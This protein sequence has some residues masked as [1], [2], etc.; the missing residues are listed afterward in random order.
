M[1]GEKVNYKPCY[2]LIMAAVLC[3]VACMLWPASSGAEGGVC[4]NE[5]T[6]SNSMVLDE[7]G[8]SPDWIEIYNSTGG[9]VNLQ[10]WCLSDKPGKLTRWVFPERI[11]G[12]GEYLLV[13][14]SGKHRARRSEPLHTDFKISDNDRGIYL[15]DE[16]GVLQDHI[17]I[18]KLP[19]DISY[20]RHRDTGELVYFPS[21]TP[22]KA[23]TSAPYSPVV[24]YSV[25][26]GFY[27]E[28]VSVGLYTEGTDS[29]IYY[30]IDGST[31][32]VA[33]EVYTEPVKIDK[34]TTIRA[35]S[36]KGGHL[37]SPPSGQTYFIGFDSKG[38]AVLA[39]AT[40]HDKLWDPRHGLFR[41]ITYKDYML[42][43]SV[44]VH[45]SYFDEDGNQGFSQDATIG[46]VGA[47]SREV[48]MRP[49]KINAD[50][51]V[52]PMHEEFKYKLLKKDIEA[53]RHIQ[54]RN[55]NQ[56][57]VRY[58]ADPECMPTMGM[59]NALFC[60]LVRGLEGIE[61]R[62]DN[63]PVLF[64]IN[65]KNYGMMNIGEKRDNTGISEN[66]P[67]VR[68]SDVDLVVVR[69]DM[70]M[71]IGRH[72]LG[73]GA[74]YIRHDSRVVYKGYVQDGAIEYEEISASARRTGSTRAV[75]DFIALDPT[76]SSQ[77]DPKGYIASMAAHTIACNTDYGMNNIAFW[78]EA[79]VG[80]E[81][82][83]FH[84]YTFDF[85]STFG[86]VKWRE[87]YDTLLDY[88]EY[89]RLFS[90]FMSKEEYRLAFI[91]K[92][93]EYLNGP[94]KPERALAV[95]DRLER[96]MEPW[97]EQHLE[98]WADGRMDREKWKKN[99]KH[100]K[101]F[102][103]V[104]PKYVRMHL[105]S[106]FD[107]PG[108]SEM[109][110]QVTPEDNGTIYMDTGVFTTPLEG[111][112]FYAKIPM[113]IHARA[114]RG[115]E[116]SHFLIDGREIAE[117]EYTFTPE[118]GMKIQ[119]VFTK[120]PLAP[121]ADLCINEVVRAGDLKLI[122]EDGNRQDWIEIYN[123]TE[124]SINMGGMY[125]SDDE[126]DLKKWRFPDVEIGPGEFLV[127]FLSGKNRKDPGKNLHSNFKLSLE[128]LFLV[129]ADGEKITDRITLEEMKSI[130]KDCSG[131]KSPDGA[132]LFGSS[133]IATP[134]RPN[135]KG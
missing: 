96:K 49:L 38:I 70:G 85:D 55:N 12:P 88:K 26:G 122:D 107:F 7:D 116:F 78:R 102:V 63:G 130:E 79:P 15:S 21:P 135:I 72:M 17:T 113:K 84:T 44:R 127:V 67:S 132:S 39:L 76:D 101:K 30:T 50:T 58:L 5:I 34:N 52:D 121:V 48:M 100:L 11:M 51:P 57:G 108:Y 43:E 2:I 134:G 46:V 40:E 37:P 32:T 65:G 133:A 94:F 99:V 53:F 123:V 3:A 129:D 119:A 1:Q 71:R 6:G 22:G 82:G 104:R 117:T 98:L 111:K 61:I 73:K 115:A 20:G 86:L 66:N 93:D 64:F 27:S 59:R 75:D 54:L 125:I 69:D 16:A 56:D 9:K 80:G 105:E 10:G 87:D 31:P 112:G 19:Q 36:L 109:E 25:G 92:I 62:D 95:I 60:D 90:K 124:S 23:N 35:I 74:A 29:R 91:R 118:D 18:D 131:I 83:P 77:L 33:S 14:A 110:F 41:D 45:V 89:T 128:P 81:P 68:S 106:F 120:A 47:S 126:D 4:I 8:D 13:F 24:K 114:S 103:S 97:I 28:P 42:R